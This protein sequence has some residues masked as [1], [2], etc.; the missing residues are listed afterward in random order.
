MMTKDIFGRGFFGGKH[1]DLKN[2]QKF[3]EEWE[4]MSDNEKLDNIN[5]RIEAFKEGKDHER[6]CLSV[7]HIDA[8]CEEW[9]N[10][11]PEE[12]VQFVEYLKQKFEKHQAMMKGC[13]FHHGF[14]FHGKD[15]CQTQSA[16]KK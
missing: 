9:M 16:E 1:F 12:K 11:T 14:G 8:H 4:T 15:H 6:G 5:K 7:E 2:R 13:F 3:I 10:K